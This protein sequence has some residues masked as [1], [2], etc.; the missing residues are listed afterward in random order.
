MK[1]NFI[2]IKT[3]LAYYILTSGKNI[4]FKDKYGRDI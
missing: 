2:Q 1:P 3:Y 4:Q